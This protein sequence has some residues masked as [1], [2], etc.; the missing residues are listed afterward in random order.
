MI[1]DMERSYI[2]AGF[3]RYTMNKRFQRSRLDLQKIQLAEAVQKSNFS[4]NQPVADGPFAADG[5]SIASSM[6]RTNSAGEV[7][8]RVR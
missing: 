2:T 7:L 1:T 6:S 8:K 3:F 5:T 4:K